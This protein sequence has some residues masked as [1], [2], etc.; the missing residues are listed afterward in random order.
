MD[1]S[2][3]PSFDVRQE[4]FWLQAHFLS[5]VFDL[6]KDLPALSRYL[7]NQLGHY[8]LRLRNMRFEAG[9]G[10][11]EE[12]SLRLSWPNLAEVR[13]FLDRVEIDSEYLQF[14]RFEERDLVSDVL[15]V[16]AEYIPDSRFRTYSVTQEVHGELI[17]QP[18]NE[19]LARFASSAPEGFGPS[20]G[21]GIVFYFGEEAERLFSSLT[22][23]F[24]RVVGGGI[25]VQSVVLYD[26]SRV[27]AGEL[28]IMSRSHFEALFDRIGLA[29]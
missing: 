15:G 4:R 26:A 11:L 21:M 25:F 29:R 14:L 5:P 27:T 2:T 22:F 8:N 23:D 20:L 6:F 3:H 19:F 12:D 10:S 7:F 13:I 16:V 24:S 1:S 9:A 28:Q 18:R 17:G